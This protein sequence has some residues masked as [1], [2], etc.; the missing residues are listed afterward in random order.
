MA[1]T[2]N[3]VITHTLKALNIIGAG[4]TPSDDDYADALLEYEG[5]HDALIARCRD[6]WRL[7]NA[8]WNKD[9]VPNNLFPH[10][11]RIFAMH[12]LGVFPDDGKVEKVMLMAHKA[13]S[14][15]KRILSRPKKS[16]KRFPDMPT[17][18]NWPDT[19]YGYRRNYTQS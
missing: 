12:L 4:E 13:E 2:T 18:A 6:A 7:Q 3:D 11:T 5:F 17:T 14:D 19:E 10:V 15:L 1:K 9:S 16:N 8:N